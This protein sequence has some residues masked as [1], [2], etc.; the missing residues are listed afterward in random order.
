MD[1]STVPRKNMKEEFASPGPEFRPA[2]FWSWNSVMEE[3]E[4]RRQ[5]ADFAAHG[6]GGAFAHARQGLVTEYLSDDFFAAWAAAL[7]ES[8]KN[9]VFLY[10]YDENCWP[11]GFAGGLTVEAGGEELIG[12]LAKT[13]FV[14]AADPQFGGELLFAAQCDEDFVLGEDLTAIPREQWGD[15]AKRVMV[16]YRI[17][18]YSGGCGGYAYVD[19]TNRKTTETFLKVTYDEY[20]KRFGDDFGTVI[21]A[22]FSDEANINSEGTNTVPYNP[23]VIET[24]RKITGFELKDCLPAIFRN[25]TFAD[26]NYRL[27][28]PA[29]KLRHDYYLTLHTLWIENFVR[30]VTDWCGEHRIAWTGHDIE[31]QWPQAHGGRILPSEQHTYEYRQW[32]GLDLLLCD[33]LRD[34]P[35]EFDKLE[36][37][38]IR[39]AANQFSK[40]RTLC[41]AYGAGGYQSTVD[42]YK[43]MGDYLL[44]YGI[45]FFVPHLSLY[46]YMGLRKRDCPQSF[47]SHQP[48]WREWTDYNDYFA[49]G[50]YMLTR[51]KMEQRIL[52]LNPSTTSYLVPGEEAEGDVDHKTDPHSIKNPDMSDF[53]ELLEELCVE[54]WDFDLGDEYSLRDNGAVECGKLT[55]GAMKYDAVVVSKNMKNMFS[56]T[57]RLVSE[58][59]KAGGTVISTGDE[60]EDAAEYIDGAKGNSATAELRSSW[61]RAGSPDAVTDLLS[62]LFE[63]HAYYDPLTGVASMCR[64]LDDGREIFFIVNHSMGDYSTRVSLKA[65][66]VARWDM[67]TGETE[68]VAV[69]EEKNGY[70]SFP[71]T[72]KRCESALFVTDGK[73]LPAPEKP[74]EE[75]DIP[76]TFV[77]A[78]PES[79]N[80]FT[81]DHPSLTV[82]GETLPP[83][84]FI[85][86]CDELHG[87]MLG[88][89]DIWLS[90][91][92]RTDFL[93]M[94]EKFGE[95]SAFELNYKFEVAPETVGLPIR[96]AYERP[97]VMHLSVNGKE[98][99]WGG[100]TW[101]LGPEFGV[102][103]ITEAIEAGE[104]VLTLRADRFDVL[105]EVEAAFLEGDFSVSSE[106]GRFIL[107][108]G[109]SPEYG[110]WTKQGMSHYH[111]AVLYEF[112][113]NCEDVPKKA[114]FSAPAYSA[115]GASL[116]VNGEY[117]GAFGINGRRSADVAK[118]LKK[119]ENSIVLRICASFQNLLG[120]HLNYTE[121]IPYDWSPFERGREASADEYRFF[122]WGLD[123]HPTLE[124]RN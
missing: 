19:L 52:Y 76:L 117:A 34:Y 5:V 41:E 124:I 49:R 86:V 1:D 90:M 113:F 62:E 42:D 8:K 27:P 50:S 12:D 73:P 103:D 120:P 3:G 25:V 112:S 108:P 118:H 104:N 9:G 23:Q 18:P 67:V 45:N 121:C 63:K 35:S 31:H 115:T 99:P 20:F 92:R 71:L 48:W 74:E 98:I 122:D 11:S 95:E 51:G 72:L 79:E 47:D 80:T 29:E 107:S 2:P 100:D 28:A 55:V 111:G 22:V 40:E 15:H 85:E 39:S 6:F 69:E 17:S 93:D 24:Y 53:L 4:V 64:R 101:L 38:E 10:M 44:V 7:D 87:K 106:D 65:K 16:I 75:E 84:Y 70:V 77:S 14:D 33:H 58:F 30:P 96:A 37:I 59:R 66:T 57:A 36:M 123:C 78:T 68:G 91:Q 89:R 105:C 43:R 21:P 32:P 119:G 88:R 81:L 94:N 83:R 60:E 13:R 54:G 114:V 46:S 26:G 97:S 56:S 116:T 110:P 82:G 61:T 109:R 102:S